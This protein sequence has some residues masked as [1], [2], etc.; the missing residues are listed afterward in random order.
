MTEEKCIERYGRAETKCVSAHTTLGST[1][2][3][4]KQCVR[5][6]QSE[7]FCTKFADL[8]DVTCYI[9][10]EELC[11]SAHKLTHLSLIP[12]VIA[13]INKLYNEIVIFLSQ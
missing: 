1:L 2:L 6:N 9:C 11:N 5:A 3:V 13:F 8:K 10:D 7:L 12:V 4:R